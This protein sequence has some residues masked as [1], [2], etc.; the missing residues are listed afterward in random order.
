[1]KN[2][3][4]KKKVARQNVK[5]DAQ[6]KAHPSEEK[7]ELVKCSNS[8]MSHPHSCLYQNLTALS[9][10]F[11]NKDSGDSASSK[12]SHTIESKNGN[13]TCF[14]HSPILFTNTTWNSLESSK[15]SANN[16]YCHSIQ[17]LNI[18]STSSH[19]IIP[20]TMKERWLINS[21]Y[22]FKGNRN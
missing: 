13:R 22:N 3:L 4:E 7:K 6:K 11:K 8:W 19:Y 5:E 10:L 21:S 17:A 12:F 14:Y 18:K 16:A 20:R 1:M 9:H 15:F 2:P